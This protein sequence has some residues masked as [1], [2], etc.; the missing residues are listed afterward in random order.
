MDR[1]KAR[2]EFS[3]RMEVIATHRQLRNW[4]HNGSL[5]AWL[6]TGWSVL[7]ESSIW[8]KQVCIVVMVIGHRQTHF[9]KKT[10]TATTPQNG[11]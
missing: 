10:D 5:L 3:R 2:K 1:M 11:E 4:G 7:G 9:G 6:L 8:T